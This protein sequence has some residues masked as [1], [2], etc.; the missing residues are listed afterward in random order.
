MADIIRP[1]DKMKQL[2]AI[3]ASMAPRAIKFWCPVVN[4]EIL[5][6]VGD[7]FIETTRDYRAL[8]YLPKGL[9]NCSRCAE[10]GKVC[11]VMRSKAARKEIV[12][13]YMMPRRLQ[14]ARRLE[15]VADEVNQ[16]RL[17]EE[18]E[19][20]KKMIETVEEE[21]VVEIVCS[22]SKKKVEVI[23]KH[24]EMNIRDDVPD[25]RQALGYSFE[26]T[27]NCPQYEDCM[28]DKTNCPVLSNEADK[29]KV[30]IEIL[31]RRNKKRVGL[32]G[33]RETPKHLGQPNLSESGKV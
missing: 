27:V 14:K 32:P 1:K 22:T 4:K 28:K 18:Y 3:E 19:E 15:A 33:G 13:Q 5:M 16:L 11:Y 6:D 21:T 24:L 17:L 10:I 2:E 20:I 30:I 7:S 29:N 25:K 26:Y 31:E 12:R 8:D 23:V 9:I